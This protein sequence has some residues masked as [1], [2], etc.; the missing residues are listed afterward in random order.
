MHGIQ[1]HLQLQEQEDNN[2]SMLSVDEIT[3]KQLE[4]MDRLDNPN[5]SAYYVTDMELLGSH[6]PPCETFHIPPED[7]VVYVSAYSDD[8]RLRNLH[9][10]LAS[11]EE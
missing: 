9:F 11:G 4:K 7:K 3:R 8:D 6:T 2:Y 10:H 5:A 1:L